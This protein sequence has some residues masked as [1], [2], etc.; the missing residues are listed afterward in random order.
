M[1][2]SSEADY[3]VPEFGSDFVAAFTSQDKNDR[4]HF[5]IIFV[6]V[7]KKIILIKPNQITQK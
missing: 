7:S 6:V 1:E 5:L 3:L 2:D 4:S